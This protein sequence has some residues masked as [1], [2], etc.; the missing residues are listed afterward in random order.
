MGASVGVTTSKKLAVAITNIEIII[1]AYFSTNTN[2]TVSSADMNQYIYFLKI[3]MNTDAAFIINFY[4][5]E[6]STYN[7]DIDRLC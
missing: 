3:I 4:A 7:D 2:L 5:T 6:C 1:T